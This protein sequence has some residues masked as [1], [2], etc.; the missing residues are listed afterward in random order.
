MRLYSVALAT[1][2]EPAMPGDRTASTR[3]ELPAYPIAE[4]A[5]YLGLAPATLR[6]WVKGR[7][8]PTRKGAGRF[9]PLIRLPEPRQP[10]LSFNNLVEAHVLKS[11]RRDHSV[12]LGAVRQALDYA[13]RSCHVPRLLL[14]PELRA[15]AG[16][17]FLDRYGA[18]LSLTPSGQYALRKVLE[19]YLQRVVWDRTLPRRLYPFVRGDSADAPRDIVID[20]ELAFG[21]PV[22]ERR[23]ISTAAIVQR[24]DAG[25]TADVIA[26][27]YELSPK[28]VE[29]AV[30]YER[31]A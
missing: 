11:L 1:R 2:T 25:E 20:P 31:A 27:D 15:N 4:A 13:Q 5:R 6:S 7:D 8:Y 19:S 28:E 3:R 29:E 18:L 24:F 30:L 21:R 16:Q 17:L 9:T 10:L 22:V 26:A 23:G 12:S 14:S